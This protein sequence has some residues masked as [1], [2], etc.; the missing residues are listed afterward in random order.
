NRLPIYFTMLG[1]PS[2]NRL[3]SW[4]NFEKYAEHVFINQAL[5]GTIGSKRFSKVLRWQAMS[6]WDK[7]M[8]SIPQAS[9]FLKFCLQNK[10]AFTH[11]DIVG[12]LSLL[13]TRRHFDLQS[14]LFKQYNDWILSNSSF[15]SAKLHLVLH[16]YG[17]L[18]YSPALWKLCDLIAIK[19]ESM[20]PK[21]I[22][23]SGWS[24]AKTSVTEPVVWNEIGRIVVKRKEDFQF[25]DLSMLSWC[26]AKL[27][28]RKPI[29]ITALKERIRNALNDWTILVETPAHVE[30]GDA[31]TQMDTLTGNI[32]NPIFFNV[33]DLC[34]LIRAFAT[35]T[36]RDINF[37]MLL[38]NTLQGLIQQYHFELTAQVE[39]SGKGTSSLWS[40]VSDLQLFEGKFIEFLCEESRKLRLDHTFNGAMVTTIV[41]AL[42]KLQVLVYVCSQFCDPRIVYQ[43]VHWVDKNGLRLHADQVLSIAIGFFALKI[44]HRGAWKRLGVCISEKGID[45]RLKEL[46][47]LISIFQRT[48]MG[49]DRVFGVLK[50]YMEVKEDFHIYG[51]K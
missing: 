23:L 41:K 51:P 47:L 45:L 5:S 27:E 9:D 24:L 2:L 39:L 4:I 42:Q 34:T 36:P 38:I 37:C 14:P 16:R 13:T 8:E 12:S 21:E 20:K 44:F 11:Q 28:R 3:M 19:L 1:N 46:K 15:L 43:L 32:A 35:L 25:Q 17:V 40:S 50:H 18:S 26:F 30:N 49:N 29:E 33:H 22:A 6:E 31:S 10:D 48:E 7:K